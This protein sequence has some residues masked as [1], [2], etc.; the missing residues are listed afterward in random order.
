MTFSQ[1]GAF[2]VWLLAKRYVRRP[3]LS[4]AIFGG[5]CLNL[6]CGDKSPLSHDATCRVVPKRGHVRALQIKALL[7]GARCGWIDLNATPSVNARWCGRRAFR[8]KIVSPLLLLS[9][10]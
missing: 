5:Q 10:A 4:S 6:E 1:R 2:R 3:F 8:M 9:K 7:F